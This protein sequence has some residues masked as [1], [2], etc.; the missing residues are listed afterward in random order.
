MS[1]T[2]KAAKSAIGIMIFVL[3]SKVLG[4]FRDIL[5]AY[6]FGSGLETDAYF[7]AN[8]ACSFI[9]VTLGAALTTTLIPIFSE[10]YVGKYIRYIT[11]NDNLLM[12]IFKKN[13]MNFSGNKNKIQYISKET[14]S[15]NK[16]NTR[17]MNNILNTTII[18][19]AIFSVITYVFSPILIKI[20]AKGFTGDQYYLAVK[21][22]RIGAPMIIFMACTS[23]FSGFL[24]GNE[25]FSATAAAGIP[26]NMVY[27][28]FLLFFSKNYGIT[29]LMVASI[30]AAFTQLIIQIPSAHN[31]KYSYKFTINIK[32]KKL[33]N[34]FHLIVP[35]VLGSMINKINT[36]VDKTLASQL[37]QGSISALN[38]ANRLISLILNVFIMA[39]TA[40]IFPVL[41][42]EF[43]KQNI[44]GAKRILSKGINIILIITIP[45]TI[46][47]IILAFPITRLLFERGAFDSSA[48]NMTALA[49]I[50]YSIALV[51]GG[52]RDILNKF[53]YSF[54]DTKTPMI[55][56]AFAVGVNIVL[57]LVLVKYMAHVGLALATSIA[58]IIG[59]I[60][61]FNSLRKKNIKIGIKN[62]INCFLK[63]GISAC[64]MGITIYLINLL[65]N[66]ISQ[67]FIFRLLGLSMTI[68]IGVVVYLFSCYVFRI[69]EIEM[70][71]QFILE[72]LSKLKVI[73]LKNFDIFFSN[74]IKLKYKFK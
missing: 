60:L 8:I 69:K 26:F 2:K 54:K 72:Y 43:S 50:F 11:N 37:I 32:D 24:K 21:L 52:L 73:I 47:I 48:T 12:Y 38:Y 29:G 23:V 53:F 3:M 74:I 44:D 4:F 71:I 68:V 36:I 46:G 22:S 25:K 1:R 67:A 7:V 57:N 30:I 17:Y 63:C 56:G 45:A 13:S 19:A 64:I 15:N 55:N 31:L 9:I 42:R 51:S 65:L 62:N 58:E 61:L 33:K 66:V 34:T 49:L 39:I 27:I 70:L 59:T 10:M 41:S 18:F 28:L 20:L 5:I 40:V 16:N 35:I 14:L 6:K